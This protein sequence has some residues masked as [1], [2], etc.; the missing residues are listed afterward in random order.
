MPRRKQPVISD[1]LL[2]QLLDGADPRS[3]F[4]PNGVLDALKKALAERM[5]NAE[6]DEGITPD[7]CLGAWAAAQQDLLKALYAYEQAREAQMEDMLGTAK[8]TAE[9]GAETMR[10][11]VEAMHLE[12]RKVDRFIEQAQ[13]SLGEKESTTVKALVDGFTEKAHEV[14]VARARVWSQTRYLQ[15]AGALAC[16]LPH[17]RRRLLGGGDEPA[18][19]RGT[20]ELSAAVRQLAA[21]GPGDGADVLRRR[22]PEPVA[23]TH[24]VI[25][26]KRPGSEPA[27]CR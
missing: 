7:T 11:Q 20:A 12:R 5:L 27:P 24:G 13:I 15:T 2:D 19:R 6:M 14:M 22:D 1:A 18:G 4:D 26:P 17:V 25:T 10:L 9:A 16:R 21:A 8:A 23:E 3:A